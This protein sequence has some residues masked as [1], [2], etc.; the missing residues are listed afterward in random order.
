MTRTEINI[1]PRLL[2][3]LRRIKKNCHD[4]IIGLVEVDL[5][6]PEFDFVFGEAEISSGVATVSLYRLEPERYGLRSD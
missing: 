4:K 3:R 6:S 1:L 5:Y 2:S